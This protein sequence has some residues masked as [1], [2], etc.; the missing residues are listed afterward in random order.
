[1]FNANVILL[2]IWG[3][4]IASVRN[5]IDVYISILYLVTLWNPHILFS[6]LNS[7][8]FFIKKITSANKDNFLLF[9]YVWFCFV[10]FCL[11]L[12]LESPIK[13][14]AKNVQENIFVLF[15]VLGGII[16]SIKYDVSHT[17]SQVHFLR[18]RKFPFDFQF[19]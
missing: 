16:Y 17:L 5:A 2:L 11:M 8:W 15:Q 10:L 6:F 19:V 1:M 12:W 3:V 14:W 7:L 13:C 9:K 4:Q 18:L